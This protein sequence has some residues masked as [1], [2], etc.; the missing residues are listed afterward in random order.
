MQFGPGLLL[1][2]TC[3]GPMPC[4]FLQERDA[5]SQMELEMQQVQQ[6][7][8]KAAAAAAARDEATRARER[9]SIAM[10]GSARPGTGTRRKFG[11]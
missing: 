6:D 9:S 5:R 1:L 10:T 8:A 7:K 3:P 2:Q 11:L 4:T